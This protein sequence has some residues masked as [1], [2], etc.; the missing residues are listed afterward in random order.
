MNNFSECDVLV[1]G[2]G[3]AGS[4]IASLLAQQQ[5]RVV[6]LEQERF[7]RFHIGESLLPL[8]LPLFER[9]GVADDVRRIGV[10]KPGAELVSDAHAA[11]GTFRFSDNPYLSVGHSYQVRRAEFDKLLLDNS[12]RL[13]AEV[14]EEVRVADVVLN[15]GER[16]RITAI[17][18]NGGKT[19]WL[20]RFLV[21]AT[22]RDT[23]LARQLGLKRI[24]KRNNTAAV[25]GHFRNVPCRPGDK[26]GMIT[27]YLFDHGWFWMIPLPDDIM[28]VGLVGTRALFK[29]KGGNI[30]ALFTQAVAA[31]PSLAAHMAKA[32]PLGP[33]TAC[34]DYSYDSRSYVG[35]SHIL[36]GDAAAF[37]DPLFSSGVMMAMSSAAFAAS[38]VDGL[39]AGRPREPIVRD[40]ESR[41]RLSL[42]SLSW[43]IYRINAPV[44]RDL[45]VS[46]F[47]LFNTRHELIT[48]LAGD[49]YDRR[50]FLSPLR[51]L[52]LAYGCLLLLS[53]FGL[54]LRGG[55]ITWGGNRGRA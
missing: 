12:R 44:L 35:E 4:T 48:V 39:L 28:S 11:A 49:F 33:L 40:Y 36:V 21:D 41:I 38:A 27:V 32:E 37:I 46:S 50:R 13:G 5:R 2:G 23:L 22:G 31:T 25:F 47:D 53:K 17:D 24:D 10:Y 45:L 29:A 43:L 6:L 1:V 54:R 3:P 14:R 9:L 19:E 26:A 51:R 16:P 20:P 30:D 15:D 42:T 7:P 18:K 8:N 52:Q 55:G 34:A